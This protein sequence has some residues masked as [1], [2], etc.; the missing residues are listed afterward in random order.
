MRFRFVTLL[1]AALSP[2]VRA[3]SASDTTL[4]PPHTPRGLDRCNVPLQAP[5]SPDAGVGETLSYDV[6]I[7][8]LAAGSIDL[9]VHRAKERDGLL[10]TEYR[11]D[12]RVARAINMVVPMEFR[13]T[14]LVV[15]ATQRPVQSMHRYRLAHR[16][17]EEH[18]S[19]DA[20]ARRVSSKRSTP[21]GDAASEREFAAPV[22]DFLS[23]VYFLRRLA[24]DT[25]GCALL[26]GN[27][28][29]YTVWITAEGTE[30]LKT[31]LGTR[32][33]RRYGIRYAADDA[34][35][36]RRARLWIG[37]DEARLPLRAEMIN[38][39][40]PRLE[41]VQYVPPRHAT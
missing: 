5:P 23:G 10:L 41:L 2:T 30:K 36:V 24:P 9:R 17:A 26:Y 31:A 21:D 29:A 40:Q 37:T 28:K 11:S 35:T 34:R 13:A 38:S 18:D 39:Y 19:F 12:G 1:L 4:A 33:A 14:S 32:S 25:S 20:D 6:E 22:L 3:A 16:R 7:M 15:T 8:G 27:Q